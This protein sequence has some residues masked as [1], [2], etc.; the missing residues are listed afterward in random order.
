MQSFCELVGIE[1]KRKVIGNHIGVREK[2]REGGRKGGGSS[3]P[4][5]LNLPGVFLGVFWEKK[6]TMKK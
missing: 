6:K 1:E 2:G 5:E 3:E 4:E